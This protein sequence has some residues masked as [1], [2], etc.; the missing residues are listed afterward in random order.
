MQYPVAYTVYTLYFKLMH[1]LRW[2]CI[3]IS[4]QI[5]YY[6]DNTP[7]IIVGVPIP[8]NRVIFTHRMS[9]VSARVTRQGTVIAILYLDEL[10]NDTNT[11]N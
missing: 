4:K 6:Q 10:L 7:D 9:F 8:P 1:Q 3:I 2:H 5:A 11:R